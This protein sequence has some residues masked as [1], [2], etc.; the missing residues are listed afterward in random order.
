MASRPGL[1]VDQIV[2]AEN[3]FGWIREERICIALPAAMLAGDLGWVDADRDETNAARVEFTEVL[4]E[5]P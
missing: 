1:L 5:T 2:L 3:P 4:V